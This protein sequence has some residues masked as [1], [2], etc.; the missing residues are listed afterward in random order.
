M[1]KF[2]VWD[3]DG[4]IEQHAREIACSCAEMAA[5]S[6]AEHDSDGQGDGLYSGVGHVLN[7]KDEFGVWRKV[8]VTAEYEPT[9]YS[10]IEP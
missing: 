4:E 3:P 6:Y 2:F 8:R 7:V 5:V 10:K 1:A 9:F